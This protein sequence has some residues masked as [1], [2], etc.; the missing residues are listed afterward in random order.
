MKLFKST[1]AS[2][3]VFLGMVLVSNSRAQDQADIDAVLGEFNTAEGQRASAAIDERQRRFNTDAENLRKEI[4]R[5]QAELAKT[6][7]EVEKQKAAVAAAE[8]AVPQWESQGLG[9]FSSTEE[10]ARIAKA[11][12][13]YYKAQSK[14]EEVQRELAARSARLETA[15]KQKQDLDAQSIKIQDQNKKDISAIRGASEG[16]KGALKS[17]LFMMQRQL[18]SASLGTKLS[19][20][21]F[22]FQDDKMNLAAIKATY[23]KTLMGMYV[24]QAVS[25]AMASPEMC[26]A[27]SSCADSR[28]KGSG[29]RIRPVPGAK[30]GVLLLREDN[31]SGGVHSDGAKKAE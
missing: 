28:V 12:A 30:D 5:A 25:G 22:K 13:D 7:D 18:T 11:Q 27:V 31:P 3:M 29:D 6:S 4:E 10:K 9:W 23:D 20:L 2:F 14:V 21:T 26:K 1:F 24:K 8:R 17:T 16:Q 15:R 19:D